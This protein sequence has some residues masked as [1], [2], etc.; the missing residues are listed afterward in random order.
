MQRNKKFIILGVVWT[1][2]FAGMSFYWALG[3]MLGA[4]SLGGELSEISC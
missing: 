2:V 4:R 3:G 1:I